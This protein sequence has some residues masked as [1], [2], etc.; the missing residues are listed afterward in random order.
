MPVDKTNDGEFF[1]LFVLALALAQVTTSDDPIIQ[2][3][4]KEK[5][6][7]VYATDTI[8]STIMCAPRSNYGWDIMVEKKD[9][10]IFL[11]KRPG[12]ALDLLTVSETAQEPIVDE[13]EGINSIQRLSQEAT[14]VNQNFSQQV[15]V[16]FSSYAC[17]FVSN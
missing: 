12:S 7:N 9:G 2:K 1:G 6:G 3:L 8:L 17:M 15:M 14:V 5:I 11:D 4:V 10:N 16:A 13:K